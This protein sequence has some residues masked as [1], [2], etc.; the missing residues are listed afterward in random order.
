LE[1]R[2][3]LVIEAREN[4]PQDLGGF[5]NVYLV[6]VEGGKKYFIREEHLKAPSR[7]TCSFC[8]G[9]IPCAKNN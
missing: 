3:A 7:L 4:E 8:G 6:E 5:R 9:Q 2:R 1:G